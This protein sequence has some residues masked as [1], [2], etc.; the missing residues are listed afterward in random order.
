MRVFSSG[1][2]RGDSTGKGRFDLIPYEAL[3]RVAL[4][5]EQ[6]A[7]HYG[8]EEWKK[9]I[10]LNSLYDSAIRHL[11][12]AKAGQKDEDHLAAAL[13]NIMGICWTEEHKPDLVSDRNVTITQYQKEK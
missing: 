13:W 7:I 11:L 9:G 6:G 4:R 12:Q 5:Y 2:V 1:A 3:R 8:D 10:P